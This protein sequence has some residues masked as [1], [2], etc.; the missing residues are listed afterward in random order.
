M[1]LTLFC[2]VGHCA[3]TL[4]L[5]ARCLAPASAD[6]H[7]DTSGWP[8]GEVVDSENRGGCAPHTCM[9]YVLVRVVLHCDT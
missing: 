3:V 2:D 7:S 5:A 6:L 1:C 4:L 8:V 9:V